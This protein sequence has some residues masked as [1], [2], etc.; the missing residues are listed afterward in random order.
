MKKVMGTITDIKPQQR[1]KN[2]F[3]I[4]VDGEFVLGVDTQM[5]AEAHLTVGERITKEKIQK[6]IEKVS[7]DKLLNKVY[8]FL[9]FRPRTEKEI[10]NFLFKK[11][12]SETATALV[13]D[14]LKSQ[15]HINDR[16]FAHWWIQQRS[17]FRPK[18]KRTLK[19]ELLQKGLTGE[20]IEEVLETQISES[21]LALRAAQKG[22]PKYKKL[23]PR[24]FSRKM[25]QFLK[26]RGF[27]WE[28]IR[29]VVDQLGKKISSD[30]KSVER[31][32]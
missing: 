7:L 1:R 25:G 32:R 26:R 3:N 18:G 28:I 20:V 30:L 21:V 4:Y 6:L 8:K 23:T 5:L 19:K 15:G 22:Y 13:V 14:R 16:Q 17:K 12:V 9:A 31:K 24:E 2:R 29:E 11:K 27:S 10:R